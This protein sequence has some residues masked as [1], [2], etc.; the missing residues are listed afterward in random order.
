MYKEVYPLISDHLKNIED[1]LDAR[2]RG[3][4]G[5]EDDVESEEDSS[6]EEEEEERTPRRDR[7][8]NNRNDR[9]DRNERVDRITNQISNIMTD[10]RNEHNRDD[11]DSRFL[12]VQ[13]EAKTPHNSYDDDVAA[14]ERSPITPQF[15]IPPPKI[16]SISQAARIDSHMNDNDGTD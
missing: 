15:Y 11:V 3:V 1:R 16:Y 13:R 2:R 7:N 9:N 8:I 14:D 10:R 12:R 4:H 6:S 5:S